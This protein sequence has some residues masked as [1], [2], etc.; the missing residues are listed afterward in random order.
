M[1]PLLLSEEGKAVIEVGKTDSS[2]LGKRPVT[3][4]WP[5]SDSQPFGLRPC[6]LWEK[7]FV[8]PSLGWTVCHSVFLEEQTCIL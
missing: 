4:G 5:K 8:R 3:D 7:T 6:D 1:I 2:V